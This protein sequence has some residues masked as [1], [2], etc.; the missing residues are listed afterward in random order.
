VQSTGAGGW[1]IGKSE[2]YDRTRAIDL[3]QL[4]T[5]LDKVQ[6]T[7]GETQTLDLRNDSEGLE[8]FLT[9]LANE[10]SERGVVNVLRRGVTTGQGRQVVFRGARSRRIAQNQF[11]VIPR[12]Q[13][14]QDESHPP[15]DL[16]L[17]LNG[18]PIAT[19]ELQ[20]GQEKKSAEDA[21]ERYK[22]HHQSHDRLFAP[23][24]CL[25]HF[26]VDEKQ[27]YVCSELRADGSQFMPFNQ[28]S[29]EREG[30]PGSLFGIGTDYL[31]RNILTRPGII[32]IVENYAQMMTGVDEQ[33][34]ETRSVP[35]FP[36]YHQLDVVRRLLGDVES[37]NVGRRYLVL[38]AGGSG[39]SYSIAWLVRQLLTV[40]Q[41]SIR[42]FDRIVVV[43]DRPSVDRRLGDT[44]PNFANVSSRVGTEDGATAR[45][46]ECIENQVHVTLVNVEQFPLV[47][48]EIESNRRGRRF[49]FVIDESLPSE[50]PGPSAEVMINRAMF[51]RV[52]LPNTSTFVFAP[53]ASETTLENFGEAFN[54]RGVTRYR[55]F[56]VHTA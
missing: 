40:E 35:V 29:S 8:S 43:T 36:R 52:P 56:H 45:I 54:D 47:L 39:T 17:F 44:V 2:H 19:L 4:T 11:S 7:E 50:N 53:T 28:G 15:V 24:R 55:P 32:D 30:N 48:D 46:H 18:L 25:A 26:A 31:W 9:T 34:G 42:I 33:T 23:G 21:I 41:D 5:F 37:Y 13:Y 16:C 49:A 38:H 6:Q 27:V 12:L 10:I 1:T 3:L 14:S 22:Q 20:N 51:A